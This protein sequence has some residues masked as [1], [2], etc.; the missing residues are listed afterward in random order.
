MC[1]FM[2]LPVSNN[3]LCAKMLN[4]LFLNL[5]SQIFSLNIIQ[6][7]KHADNK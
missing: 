3:G 2:K 7:N 1:C 5:N 6:T 4:Y